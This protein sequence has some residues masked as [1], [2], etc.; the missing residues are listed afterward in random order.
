MLQLYIPDIPHSS[1]TT[2]RAAS[3]YIYNVAE[4]PVI[5]EKLSVC[6]LLELI[7]MTC[8]V[9]CQQMQLL[10]LTGHFHNSCNAFA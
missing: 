2:M 8:N 10:R 3:V 4:V 5:S 7:Y 6:M 1:S 9:H